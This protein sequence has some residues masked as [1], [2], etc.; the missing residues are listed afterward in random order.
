[1]PYICALK[2]VASSNVAIT[3]FVQREDWVSMITPFDWKPRVDV[4]M[5]QERDELIRNGR[6]WRMWN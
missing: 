6:N 5:N 4:P 2:W 3:P 1:M